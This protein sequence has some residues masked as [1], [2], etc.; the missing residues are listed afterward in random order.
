MVRVSNFEENLPKSL[1]AREFVE[2][3]AAGKLHAVLE[4]MK[5]NKELFDVVIASDT[6]IYFEGNIIGKP[7]DAK[8]AF[9]TLQRS[10]AGSYGI[11]E[12]GAVFVKA[13]HGCFSN[14]V[15]LPIYKVHSALVNK[16]IL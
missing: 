12:Y 8:D 16:G 5:T 11:Q 10:R 4:E 13:V 2:Q 9:N 15:G 6:V 7:E 1:P 3:T 14:V